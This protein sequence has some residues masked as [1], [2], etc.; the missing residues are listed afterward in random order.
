MAKTQ[1]KKKKSNFLG[2]RLSEET[3]TKLD[4]IAKQQGK[5]RGL[6][7]K[8]AIEQWVNLEFFNQTNEMITISKTF[9]SNLLSSVNEEEI[10]EISKKLVELIADIMKFSVIKP[11]NRNTLPNYADF[12]TSFFGKTGLNWFNS[13]DIQIQDDH[14]I[15]RGLHDLDESFSQF[16][17]DFYQNLLSDYFKLDYKSKIEETTPN[18]IHLDFQLM[19]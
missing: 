5:T 12:S 11:M 17:V 19:K 16:F 8:D 7:A 2:F 15:F 9:F 6:V 18:L 3:L 13:F 10:I 1:Q 4:L 14:F